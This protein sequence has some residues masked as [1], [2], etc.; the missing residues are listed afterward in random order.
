MS[1]WQVELS[2]AYNNLEYRLNYLTSIQKD[3]VQII[4]LDLYFCHIVY[5]DRNF[6]KEFIEKL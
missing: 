4:P 2:V 5:R 6:N 1:Q 3:I